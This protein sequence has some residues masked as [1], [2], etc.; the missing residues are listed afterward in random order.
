MADEEGDKQQLADDPQLTLAHRY[1][2][3]L[4]SVEKRMIPT[5]KRQAALD[6]VEQVMAPMRKY[7]AALDAVERAMAPTRQYQAAL[8]AVERLMTPTRKYQDALDAVE[9]AMA[10]SHK[11]Q[12]ALDAVEKLMTP[13]RKYQAALD[14]VEK[15][16]TPTRKYQAALD[17]V[18]KLMTPT[19]KYQEALDAVEKA[20]APTRQYQAALDAVEKLMAPTRKHQEALN[21]IEKG[22]SPARKYQA[23]LEA[24]EKISASSQKYQAALTAVEKMLQPSDSLKAMMAVVD[25]NYSSTSL[26]SILESYETLQTSPIF[27]LLV[28]TDPKKVESLIEVY[29][30]EG[31]TTF[32]SF[33]L[34]EYGGAETFSTSRDVEDEIVQSLQDDGSNKK[35]TVPAMAFL[36]LFLAALH[37]FY[38]E[39]AK[40][41]D[42]R[43]S[44]CDL[45]Q[46]LQTFESLAQA[47]KV[48]RTA[49]C[50]MPEELK[51]SFRL[52]KVKGV[53]LREEPGMKAEVIL[54]LPKFAALE[55]IDSNNRDWL[56]V[57]YKH[58]GLEI[59]GWVSRKFVRPASR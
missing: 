6:A 37:T 21:A 22:L 45:E 53:N 34:E 5:G 28:A 47:R 29:E 26:R 55:V 16:M 27:N 54:T 50:D 14:A 39:M 11:Y 15:L 44:V 49:L 13:T 35:L 57:T 17:A 19:R 56:L 7:Q 4:D 33:G 3:A 10:P 8:D 31:T 12:A 25:T 32:G 41:N 48:V 40:W 30:S 42:F 9:K 52:T 1:Q 43:E 18:E 36:I 51:R 59:E 58:E 24:V 23:A 20:I 46:R 2:V 38:T